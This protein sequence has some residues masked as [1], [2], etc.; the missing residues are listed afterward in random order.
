M[1]DIAQRFFAPEECG[2]L[3]SLPPDLQPAGFFRCWTRKEAYLKAI[4][5]G[6]GVPL[7]QFIVTLAPEQAARI[8]SILGDA[9]EASRWSLR[10]L[11]LPPEYYGALVV[12]GHDWRLSCWEWAE[13]LLW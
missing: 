4:G 3:R 11:S 6:L 5:L 7:D 9:K 2:E 12:E 13:S 10:E 8:V 1:L